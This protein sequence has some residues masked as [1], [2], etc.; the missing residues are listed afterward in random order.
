MALIEW[1]ETLSVDVAEIDKQHQTLVGTLNELHDA[2]RQGKSKDVMEEIVSRLIDYTSTHFATEERYFDRFGFEHA[3][4]HKKEHADFVK[5]ALEFK[6]GF[7]SGKLGLSIDVMQFLS[8]WIS[9]HIKG[10]DKKYTE[11]FKANGLG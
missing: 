5:K 2:M 8:G 1:D 3:A 6:N 7:E 9:N 11:L 4:E 10:S